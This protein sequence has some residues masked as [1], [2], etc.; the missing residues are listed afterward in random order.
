MET[1]E[2]TRAWVEIM[3]YPEDERINDWPL[4]KSITTRDGVTHAVIDDQSAIGYERITLQD[5][6]GQPSYMWVEICPF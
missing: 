6:D 3:G 5:D 1:E 2:I 4:I